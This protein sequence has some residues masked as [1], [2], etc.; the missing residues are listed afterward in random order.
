MALLTA[1]LAGS[2]LLNVFKEELPSNWRSSFPFFLSGT[3]LYSALLG[4]VTAVSE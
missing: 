3:L 1:L 2:I 4:L